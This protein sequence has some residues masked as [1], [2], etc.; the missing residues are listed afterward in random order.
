MPR[1]LYDTERRDIVAFELRDGIVGPTEI[2]ENTGYSKSSVQ[3]HLNVFEEHPEFD[4]FRRFNG[5]Y[6]SRFYLRRN[7]RRIKRQ[8]LQ[9]R[10]RILRYY[11]RGKLRI[12]KLRDAMADYNQDRNMFVHVTGASVPKITP[13]TLLDQK[14][15]A[16]R[17]S[18][19]KPKHWNN[20]NERR[21]FEQIR[22]LKKLID[23]LEREH[24]FNVPAKYRRF[25]HRNP[26]LQD[27]LESA[28]GSR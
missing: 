11:V 16:V 19:R 3:Y 20:S 28:S 14:Q 24:R 6:T 1:E 7:Q 15:Q 18:F 10:T 12:H 22:E 27:R 17:N 4:F 25:I 2:A 8:L 5:K 26:M 23:F 21:K 13:S 9:R